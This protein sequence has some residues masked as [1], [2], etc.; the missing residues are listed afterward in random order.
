[1]LRAG[2]FS[3]QRV[4]RLL[5]RRF[6]PFYFD[7]SDRG[8]AGDPDAR[9]FVTKARSDLA[10]SAVATP[11]L[12][13]MT[14]DG[15]VVG[16]TSNYA[17]TKVVLKTLLRALKEHPGYAKPGPGEGEQGPVAR[18]RV[19]ID[20]QDLGGARR[21]L[22]RAKG[23]EAALLRGHVARLQGRLRAM[24][25]H[26]ARVDDP[27]LADDA[28]M[29]RAHALWQRGRFAELAAHLEGF[30]EESERYT[31]ARY[32]EGL[33]WY[34]RGDREKARAIW[35]ATIEARPEDPW[36]YRMDWAFVE[37]QQSRRPA[38][39]SSARKSASLLGRIGYM[40]GPHPDLAPRQGSRKEL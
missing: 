37:S 26:L 31:E 10:G 14:P 1:V 7:L 15:Q 24:E 3:D 34:H 12:L 33:A 6:V 40:G 23:D 32:H 39:F 19:L 9:R 17:A 30:P 38:S 8:F 16:E 35:K 13:V 28:R 11:P 2:P 25:R 29:E 5:N 27:D 20:I 4:I 18:A 36:V 21:A 22:A